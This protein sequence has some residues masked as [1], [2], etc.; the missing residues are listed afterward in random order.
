MEVDKKAAASGGLEVS[1][2]NLACCSSH[3][4]RFCSMAA[5]SLAAALSIY[6]DPVYPVLYTGSGPRRW[7][8]TE[9]DNN[10]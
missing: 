6:P 9:N 8:L 4:R 1:V 7:K 3:S 10:A 5:S 2:H